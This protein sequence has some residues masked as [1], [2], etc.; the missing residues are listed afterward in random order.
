MSSRLRCLAFTA[1]AFFATSGL[2]QAVAQEDSGFDEAVPYV[3]GSAFWNKP[4]S[5]RNANDGVGARAFIGTR[6]KSGL[7][8]EGSI[9]G[10]Q[11]SRDVGKGDD[12]NYQ[13]GGDFLFPFTE[14][15][16]RPFVLAGGGYINEDINGSKEGA[17]YANAGLGGLIPL[18]RS[19]DLRIE[20]RY[21]AVF[22][23]HGVAKIGGNDPL[24]DV[25]VGLGLQ[26]DIG[27]PAPPPPPKV[28][29][30]D[31][32]GVLD[33]NDACPNTPAGVL[34]DARGC[35]PDTDG[36]GVADYLDK[37]PNTPRGAPVNA[38]GCPLDS[39]GDGVPDYIDKCPNTPRGATVDATGCPLDSDRDGVPDYAD[40]CPNT[41]YG[42]KVD[43]EGCVTKTAQTIVLQ[44][45][46]FEFNKAT[47]T[48]DSKTVLNDVASGLK[49]DPKLKVELAGHTDSKGTN[50]Y[51]KRLSQNRATS[52][53]A[54]LITQ[55]VESTRMV[56]KGYGEESPTASNDTEEG[57]AQNRRVEFR[58]LAK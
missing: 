19:L 37:C 48:A 56:A 21:V 36:D 5:D 57:R 15:G 58:V 39:D 16:F 25:Q 53:R 41:P 6:L 11:A 1:V 24:Y 40:K 31:G 23:D 3:G 14:S 28:L 51:N 7:M 22:N 8:F 10:T 43:A 34:V 50:A 46:N 49:S 44:N 47:L 18:T 17:G 45:V 9:A 33:P 13:I 4:D 2:Q 12:A 29:D 35:P 52:V 30:S 38:Q 54:Y 20:G 55:G 32:D 27:R 42:L 26:A